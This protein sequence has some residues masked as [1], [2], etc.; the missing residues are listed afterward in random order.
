MN[1]MV[2]PIAF[3]IYPILTVTCRN[4]HQIPAT[5]CYGWGRK[6]PALLLSIASRGR[7]LVLV[8]RKDAI[9]KVN[10]S[11]SETSAKFMTPPIL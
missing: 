4:H 11:A 10:Y 1:L 3:C 6:C 7:N 8:S 5:V 2:V 9:R